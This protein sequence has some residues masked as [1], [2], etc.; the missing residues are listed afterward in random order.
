[1]GQA[2]DFLDQSG[3]TPETAPAAFEAL[4]M[5]EGSDWFW[6]FGAD[7][8]SGNDDE[9]D[10]LFRLHLKNVYR[11]LGT[12][13]PGELNR[14][15][16]PHAVVCDETLLATL[17]DEHWRS[18]FS[19]VVKVALL[20]DASLFEEVERRADEVRERELEAALPLI[21]RSAE[22]HLSQIVAGGD[23]FEL[24][25]GRPLDFGHWIAHRLE[26]LS[27]F[28][29]THGHAV[30][31]GMA[32]DLAYGAR[33]GVTPPALAARATSVLERLG[34][35]LWHPRLAHPGLLQGLED[36][37]QHLGGKLCLPLIEELGRE[38]TV[39]EVDRELLTECLAVPA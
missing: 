13:P 37:R 9:F 32:V 14:H 25:S 22:L 8:D 33:L 4:Y 39:D 2:R 12:I 27:D 24:G 35:P 21:R 6:W 20:R 29:L 26:V 15:I 3:A 31:V 34:L 36:F 1:M 10:H 7:Q 5:A 11:G 23:P 28:S 30:S 16:V 38:T 19:E 17:S 18:G